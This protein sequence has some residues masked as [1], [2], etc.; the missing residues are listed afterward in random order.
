M[1]HHVDLEVFQGPFDLLLELIARRRLDVT[2]VDLAEITGDYLA[3]LDGLDRLDL[4]TAT[5]FLV[6]AA[7]LVEL[8]AAR[9]LPVD[10]VE[11]EHDL[12][13]QARD[14]LYARLLEYR[15]FRDVATV[16]GERHVTEAAHHART[17]DLEPRFR[18]L[19]P[20]APLE[21][22]AVDLARLAARAT[23]PRPDPAVELSHIR[24]TF[25]SIRDAAGLVL[26][27]LEQVGTRATFDELVSGRTRSDAVVVFLAALELYKLGHVELDQETHRGP[28]AVA[29]AAADADLRVLTATA[30]G[31]DEDD[32]VDLSGDEP[33]DGPDTTAATTTPDGDRVP[34]AAMPIEVAS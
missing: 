19:V 30:A 21:T 11:D 17:V 6:V 13:A 16:L 4:E 27:R 34:V 29:R 25:L 31:E 12:L 10:D 5:R 24:R 22:T 3:S 32:D 23:A 14:L 15:A 33:V 9:L 20:D 1:T 28:L 26:D 7:T 8:K 2:E 18:R